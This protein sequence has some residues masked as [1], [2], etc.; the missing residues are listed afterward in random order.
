VQEVGLPHSTPEAPAVTAL[1]DDDVAHCAALIIGAAR[2]C[3]AKADV[4]RGAD[5]TGLS[6]VAGMGCNLSSTV[7]LQQ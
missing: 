3:L 4:E 6:I 5:T 7:D 2:E 1:H